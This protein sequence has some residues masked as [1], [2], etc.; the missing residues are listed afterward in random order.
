[1]EKELFSTLKY[2][3]PAYFLTVIT[4]GQGDCGTIELYAITTNH[5]SLLQTIT[6]AAAAKS[7]PGTILRKL[8]KNSRRIE[9][10]RSH[11]GIEYLLDGDQCAPAFAR[12][13]TRRAQ[14]QHVEWRDLGKA[15]RKSLNIPGSDSC[16]GLVATLPQM[17]A[18]L[19]LDGSAIHSMTSSSVQE[20][21]TPLE[22]LPTSGSDLKICRAIELTTRPSY[23][24]HFG[25]SVNIIVVFPE[26]CQ[27]ADERL[28]WL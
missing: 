13:E 22:S 28:L 19:H 17:M 16:E 5:E 10:L 2:Q 8:C 21:A 7:V 14:E 11:D 27:W 23:D 18:L 6:P 26:D 3:R 25:D 4:Y 20:M 1:L 12:I 15:W 24:A 9:L